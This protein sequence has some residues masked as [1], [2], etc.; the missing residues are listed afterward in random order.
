[1]WDIKTRRESL[2][3]CSDD[4]EICCLLDKHKKN[5]VIALWNN[6]FVPGRHVIPLATRIAILS[7]I[8]L[9]LACCLGSEEAP[10]TN[11]IVC[12]WMYIRPCIEAKIISNPS[13]HATYYTN[14]HLAFLVLYKCPTSI[15]NDQRCIAMQRAT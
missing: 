9:S 10:N 3:F 13:E 8:A 2:T 1:M 12:V 15:C 5:I 14:G 7:A 6:R 11:L 4:V